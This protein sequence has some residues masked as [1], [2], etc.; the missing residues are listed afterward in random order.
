MKG[1][2]W[3][4]RQQVKWLV[5]LLALLPLVPTGLLVRLMV[6]NAAGD[7][8]AAAVELASAYQEQLRQMADRYSVSTDAPS[9]AEIGILTKRVFGDELEIDIALPNEPAPPE[10]A[11]D[12]PLENLSYEIVEGSIA[13]WTIT[14]K[15]I[16]EFADHLDEQRNETLLHAIGI[17]AGV[18]IVAGCVWFAVNRRLKI[19]ELRSDLVTTVSHEMKTPVAASKVLL[20]T[21]CHGETDAETTRDYLSLLEKENDRMA[22]L[23]E[24]FLTFARLDNGQLSVTPVRCQLSPVIVEQVNLIRPQFEAK[25]GE[26]RFPTTDSLIVKTDQAA[27]KVILSNLIGNALKYGGSPP[28]TQ[29]ESGITAKGFWISVSDNGDGISSG[30]HERIFREYDR[31]D[32]Q[33]SSSSSGIGLGLAISQRFARLLG[34]QITVASDRSEARTTRF[35]LTLPV[36]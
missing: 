21:L 8:T 18:S 7:R 19:D 14:L 6:Q 11:E 4:N 28:L 16:P 15:H 34:G 9:K 20:E 17:L 13:G 33:L 36:T 29:I 30:S 22:E 23:A 35:I 3:L 26:I 1:G 27:I 31:G 25:G 32:R 5:V 10:P 12:D 24:Q 2:L